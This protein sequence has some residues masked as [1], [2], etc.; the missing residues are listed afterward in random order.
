MPSFNRFGRLLVFLICGCWPG[1]QN[2]A[3]IYNAV[4]VLLSVLLFYE[5]YKGGWGGD[6]SYKCQPVPYSTDP[7]S[8]RMAGAVRLH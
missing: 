8:M 2:T 5:G 6:Y 3:V 1:H 7:I 4:Q